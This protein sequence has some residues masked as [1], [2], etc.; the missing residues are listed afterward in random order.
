MQETTDKKKQLMVEAKEE[1]EANQIDMLNATT[2][3][4]YELLDEVAHGN[5]YFRVK[6]D[7]YGLTKSSGGGSLGGVNA[8][9]GGGSSASGS[10]LSSSGVN[11]GSLGGSVDFGGWTTVL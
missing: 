9:G 4:I 5:G 8:L 10:S 1:E 7:N 2:L 11:Y 3:K 6:V